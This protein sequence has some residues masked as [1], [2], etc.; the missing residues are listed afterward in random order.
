[1]Y[2]VTTEAFIGGG[3]ITLADCAFFPLLGYMVRRGFVFDQFSALKRYFDFAE[4]R[5]SVKLAKPGGWVGRGTDN[6]F[7]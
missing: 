6:M 3:E 5:E 7:N 4:Q 2:A 1:M